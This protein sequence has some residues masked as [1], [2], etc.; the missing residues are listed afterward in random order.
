MVMATRK[1]LKRKFSNDDIEKMIKK[2]VINAVEPIP[3]FT[4][5]I[6]T[7]S[8]PINTKKVK[9]QPLKSAPKIHLKKKKNSFGKTKLNISIKNKSKKK[10]NKS[11]NIEKL[12]VSD[13]ILKKLNAIISEQSK[14]IQILENFAPNSPKKNNF[15]NMDF[16]KLNT[17]ADTKAEGSSDNSMSEIEF[18][19]KIPE[20]TEIETEEEIM[21][22]NFEGIDKVES[23][24]EISPENVDFNTELATE[25][26]E[27]CQYTS[28]CG[29]R[30]ESTNKEECKISI[31]MLD[32]EE[33]ISE[34]DDDFDYENDAN[35]ITSEE[36]IASIPRHDVESDSD[37]LDNS[38]DKDYNPDKTK[39]KW[40]LF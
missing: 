23:N 10:S 34:C 8:S 3:I 18:V 4:K 29:N 21:A 40:S 33:S 14:I 11:N 26:K 24:N 39:S 5:K 38:S 12:E 37:F 20:T 17:A 36:D 6:K 19:E 1:S 28:D 9:K 16:L 13:A 15:W 27:N 32:K 35:T 25:T 2:E 31:A 30:T 7:M 22:K